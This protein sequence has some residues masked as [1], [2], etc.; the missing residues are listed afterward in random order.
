MIETIKHLLGYPTWGRWEHLELAN[1]GY[2]RYEIL[3]CTRTDGMTKY[4]CVRISN[5]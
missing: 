2:E 5:F 4:K 1:Y 3:K